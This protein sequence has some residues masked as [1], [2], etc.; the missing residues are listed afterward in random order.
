MAA[1]PGYPV[2]VKI[3]IVS[4]AAASAMGQVNSVTYGPQRKQL[5]VSAF[6]STITAERYIMG[7]NSG[8]VT[9]KT[10]YDADDAVQDVLRAAQLSGVDVYVVLHFNPSG[11][12][13]QKGYQV[14]CKCTDLSVDA[15]VDGKV[16]QSF[17][18]VFS[19]AATGTDGTPA[20][21]T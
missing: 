5:N 21:D 9:I 2:Q 17:N 1:L 16:E 14:L 7:L 4:F 20:V 3:G 6:S 10:D 8:R 19:N 18:L 13:G 12:V 11:S 15:N